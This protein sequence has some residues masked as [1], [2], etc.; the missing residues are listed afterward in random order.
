MNKKPNDHSSPK[1]QEFN[2]E[3]ITDGRRKAVRSIIAGSG[4]TA[5]ATAGI[6][7]KPVLDAVILPAHAQTSVAAVMLA[8]NVSS[9][10]TA[11]YTAPIQNSV[12]DF[13]VGSV[14]AQSSGLDLGGACITMAVEGNQFS[15]TLEFVADPAITLEGT[16]SGGSFNATGSGVTISGAVVSDAISTAS[17]MVSNSNGTFNFS[18]DSATNSCEPIAP[19][20]TPSPTATTLAPTTTTLAPT[21]TTLAPT[22]TPALRT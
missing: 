12:L 1:G 5:A 4:I 11:S 3:P 18:A 2:Q 21:T 9:S 14:H 17:G 19:T 20:T 15:A 22:T 10:P 7:T 16:V 13:F 8:G 6:W